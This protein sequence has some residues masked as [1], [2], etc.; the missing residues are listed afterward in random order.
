VKKL[1]APFASQMQK[2]KTFAASFASQM[3]KKKTFGRAGVIP[4]FAAS[5]LHLLRKCKKRRP[6]VFFF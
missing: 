4:R 6:S 1:A 3:Q 2:K 5:P